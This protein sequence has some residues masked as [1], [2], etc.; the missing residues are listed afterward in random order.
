[1]IALAVAGPQAADDGDVGASMM[2]K[3]SNSRDGC[4]APAA[5]LPGVLAAALA[6]GVWVA[7]TARTGVTYHL[8]PFVVAAALPVVARL[9]GPALRRLE[10]AI[11]AGG[12]LAA[13]AAGWLA[14]VLLDA[15]PSATF[16]ADQPGGV[17]GEAAVFAFI[18]AGFGLW[19][20]LRRR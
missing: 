6:T 11:G 1:M 12:G 3:M 15:V 8:F 13:V 4:F 17:P 5:L 16:V 20:T 7:L 14:L 2:S 10:A 18:G 19:W 9:G